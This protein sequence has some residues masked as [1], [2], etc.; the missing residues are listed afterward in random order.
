MFNPEY[1]IVGYTTNRHLLLDLDHTSLDKAEYITQQIMR[2]WPD[3][4]D[5]IILETSHECKK[6]YM[7]MRD[8]LTKIWVKWDRRSYHVV[9]GGE[10][11]FY[12]MHPIYETL[13][14]LNIVELEYLEMRDKRGDMTLRVSSRI[15]MDGTQLPPAYI[16]YINNRW[17]HG[18]NTGIVDYLSYLTAF[19]TSHRTEPVTMLSYPMNNRLSPQ[20]SQRRPLKWFRQL[21]YTMRRFQRRLYTPSLPSLLLFCR[22]TFQHFNHY[23]YN[24]EYCASHVITDK[25][26]H[27]GVQTFRTMGGVFW[28]YYRW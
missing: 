25:C 8:G 13:V 15:L 7:V 2:R 3:V 19:T 27:F 26:F 18:L 12:E 24:T 11:N 22:S 21:L 23:I 20:S 10:M 4:G 16:E 5:A 14:V 1:I 6:D 9:F 28:F 17:Y